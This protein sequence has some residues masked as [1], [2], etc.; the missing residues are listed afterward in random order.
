EDLERTANA[1]ASADTCRSTGNVLAGETDVAGIGPKLTAQ[2]IEQRFLASAMWTDEPT[3]LAVGHIQRH[4]VHGDES[5][6][7]AY[8]PARAQQ[9]LT[10][11][12]AGRVRHVG[13]HALRGAPIPR[14]Y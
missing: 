7:A 4:L 9:F 14:G 11:R 2:D 13:R 8:K 5:A 12:S 10:N 1:R 6:K 3:H